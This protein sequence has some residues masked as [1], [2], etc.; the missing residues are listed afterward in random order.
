LAKL[1]GIAKWLME[2]DVHVDIDEVLKCIRE[3]TS[4]AIEKV[5]AL[6]RQSNKMRVFGG[7]NLSIRQKYHDRAT[8]YSVLGQQ[9]QVE[10]KN[11]I[12]QSINPT[13]ADNN[14]S[15]V[16]LLP[17]VKKKL[18][19]VCDRPLDFAS[20]FDRSTSSKDV[21]CN[22]HHPDACYQCMLPLYIDPMSGTRSSQKICLIEEGDSLFRYHPACF[23]CDVCDTPIADQ[24]Y[25]KDPDVMHVY[26]HVDCYSPILSDNQS[27]TQ[28]KDDIGTFDDEE[29]PFEMALQQSKKEY[30][31]QQKRNQSSDNFKNYDDHQNQIPMPRTSEDEDSQLALG[32]E[33][34]L[35][36][37][38]TADYIESFPCSYCGNEF[39]TW[40]DLAEHTQL[41]F[42]N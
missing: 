33:L 15:M 42:D 23:L 9:K 1:Q 30:E 24:S 19:S 25:R 21:F 2:N 7:V 18:C 37:N 32:L 14:G 3:S 40:D 38:T 5:P 11:L 20:L 12:R 27:N 4:I 16:V 17:F 35:Q 31:L 28:W 10:L 8:D 41:H 29:A 22:E 34:S 13:T 6:E 39:K 26:Y 36:T